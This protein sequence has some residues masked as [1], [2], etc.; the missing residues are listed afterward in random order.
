MNDAE[1]SNLETLIVEDIV[2]SQPSDLEDS[3]VQET[4]VEEIVDKIVDITQSV[5]TVSIDGNVEPAD[6]VQ[7][8]IT[9]PTKIK[10]TIAKSHTEDK[11]A[12]QETPKPSPKSSPKNTSNDDAESLDKVSDF[13]ETADFDEQP[14]PPGEEMVTMVPAD[15][16]PKLRER[17]LTEYPLTRRGVGDS[18]LCSIM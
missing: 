18:G 15:L 3:A 2:A 10:I 9:G 7:H 5:S 12:S 8:L 6:T 14:P 4:H 13:S 11:T 17:K 1:E 16:K